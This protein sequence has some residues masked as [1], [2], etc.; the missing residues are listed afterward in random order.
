MSEQLKGKSK[1][2]RCKNRE[3]CNTGRFILNE[4]HGLERA[5]MLDITSKNC[6]TDFEEEDVDKGIQASSET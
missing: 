5:S 4:L 6:I 1:C 3:E 2:E